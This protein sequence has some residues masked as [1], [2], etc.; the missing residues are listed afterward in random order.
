[1]ASEDLP[2]AG[3]GGTEAPGE[4]RNLPAERQEPKVA[5]RTDPKESGVFRV[6]EHEAADTEKDPYPASATVARPQSSNE[7]NASAY[8]QQQD[9][10]LSHT[11][12]A[13]QPA[14]RA[15]A[16]LVQEE[17]DAAHSQPVRLEYSHQRAQYPEA[18][19]PASALG[20]QEASH[21]TDLAQ[22][23]FSHDATASAFCQQAED[24]HRNTVPQSLP[25]AARAAHVVP[26][27]GMPVSVPTPLHSVHIQPPGPKCYNR[28]NG[29]KSNPWYVEEISCLVAPTALLQAGGLAKLEE[30]SALLEALLECSSTAV[31]DP[32][33]K[34]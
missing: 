32:L 17:S 5:D 27:Y 19:R 13:Q 12:E 14:S 16:M 7:N 26:Q 23:G 25:E 20:L 8:P 2:L 33:D 9:S 6:S 31:P 4:D 15:H 1:M 22:A 34:L 29:A 18:V 28:K 3:P 10:F 24:V 11:Q 21:Q 30:T